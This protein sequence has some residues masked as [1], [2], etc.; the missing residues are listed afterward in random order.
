MIDLHCAVNA[1]RKPSTL[2]ARSSPIGFIFP[3][4]TGYLGRLCLC[5]G[6]S[7]RI[8]RE[9]DGAPTAGEHTSIFVFLTLGRLSWT[10]LLWVKPSLPARGSALT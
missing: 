5:V 3:G 4:L 9:I 2:F 6:S 10:F 7:S 8:S 1:H